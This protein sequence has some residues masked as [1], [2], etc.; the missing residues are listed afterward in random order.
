M[1][2]FIQPGHTITLVAPAEVKSGDVVVVGG[3]AGVAAYDAAEG[4]E[5]ET[6][7]EGVFDLPKGADVLAP[8]AL[9]FWDGAK[10]VAAAGVDDVN[11]LLGAVVAAAGADVGVCRVRLNGIAA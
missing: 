6:Q 1:R 3:L 4:A 8:G 5:V 11:R 7:L 9:A 2:N 10:V